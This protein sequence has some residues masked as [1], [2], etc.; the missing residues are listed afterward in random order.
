[1]IL[2]PHVLLA[3]QTAS[4]QRDAVVREIAEIGDGLFFDGVAFAVGS[5]QKVG[6]VFAV[7]P[8]PLGCHHV[9]SPAWRD[10]SG[11]HFETMAVTRSVCNCIY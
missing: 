1:V 5:H 11:S 4:D 9:D 8:L 10:L 2:S 7:R 3:R 6:F